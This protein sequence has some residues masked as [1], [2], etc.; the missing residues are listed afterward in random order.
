MLTILGAGK[1]ATALATVL[2]QRSR[3]VLLYSIEP[4]VV[5]E[6]N[7]KHTNK[8][9][10][11]EAMLPSYV[12]ATNDIAEAVRE[13][14][15]L[16]I[17]VP[18]N[19]VASVL[20]AARPHLHPD[21]IIVS[22]TKGIDSDTLE[23]LILHQASILPANLRERIVLLGGPVTASELVR[24]SITALV[25]ASR[26]LGYAEMV[27]QT[28]EH[29]SVRFHTTT[30]VIGVGLSST[31]KNVYC[32]ALGMCDGLKFT[33]NVK[34]IV[35]TNAIEE[36]R[37]LVVAAGGNEET[38]LQLAGIGDLYVSS[39]SKHSQNRSFGQL[40]AHS[41]AKK[42]QQ[43]P[44]LEGVTALKHALRLANQH[45]LHTPLL[46]TIEQC[47]YGRTPSTKPLQ[48]YLTHLRWETQPRHLRIK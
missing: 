2:S 19:A 6:I 21:V 14:K 45:H 16:F 46:Y 18:S 47:L 29:A 4:N 41:G 42:H 44:A 28:F 38:V 20:A 3:R 30:D 31:L 13:A 24:S 7:Q 1:I 32:L 26:H 39:H 17:A 8:N 15:F 9:Y 12:T 35:F 27:R 5:Q 33:N 11:P 22:I 25:A 34:A 37:A 48:R 23:P 36:M 10:L 43:I 40:L